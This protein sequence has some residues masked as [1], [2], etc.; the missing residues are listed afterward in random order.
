MATE[1]PTYAATTEGGDAIR[2]AVSSLIATREI[3]AQVGTTY[4]FAI[5]D[6]GKLVTASNGSPQTYTVPT[7]ATTAI[8]IGSRIDLIGLGTGVVTIAPEDGTVSVRSA[9]TLVLDGQYAIVTLEKIATNEWYVAGNLV[10]AALPILKSTGTAKGDI[11]GF[12]GSATPTAL[13]VGTNGHVLT[14]DSAEATGVKWAAAAGGSSGPGLPPRISSATELMLFGEGVTNSSS[15][16]AMVVD[17]FYFQVF[18][19]NGSITL[20]DVKI[21][22]TTAGTAGST[23]RLGFYRVDDAT[24]RTFTLVSDCGTVAIDATGVVGITGLSVTLTTG[25]YIVGLVPSASVS[26][27]AYGTPQPF[28]GTT[29]ASFYREP[30]FTLTFGA[31]AL[32]VTT[33]TIGGTAGTIAGTNAFVFAIRSA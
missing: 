3:N 8:P 9:T 23:A 22:V 6:D 26:V 7:N 20:S 13:A 14:A 33:P 28:I 30:Y 32:T 19:V 25:W 11:I 16:R 2:A 31:L 17:R 27:R 10:E 12:T 24:S 18:P 15:A 4:S 1:F 29:T 5:A 21:E